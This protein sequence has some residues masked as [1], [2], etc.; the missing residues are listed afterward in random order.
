MTALG[1]SEFFVAAVVAAFLDEFFS[2]GQRLSNGTT[3]I[4][5]Y[6]SQRPIRIFE[7]TPE[8]KFA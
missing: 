2:G 4:A 1:V 6:A 7:V 8:K 3:V 5:R